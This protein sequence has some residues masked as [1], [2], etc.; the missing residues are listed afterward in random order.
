MGEAWIGHDIGK[1]SSSIDR[2]FRDTML[3]AVIGAFTLVCVVPLFWRGQ[4]WQALL[5]FVLMPLPGVALFMALSFAATH[6]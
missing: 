3:S 2:E 6:L 1:V 4:P 5:A